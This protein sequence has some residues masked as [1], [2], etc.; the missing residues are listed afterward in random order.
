MIQFHQCDRLRHMNRFIYIQWVRT[1]G[2]GVAKLATTGTD[3]S[4]NH[5]CGSSLS[6][7]FPHIGA[8]PTAAYRMQAVGVVP[9]WENAGEKELP[10]L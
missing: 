1:S 9:T 7:A 3:I 10:H 5:K 4:A 2:L 6:P 8:T